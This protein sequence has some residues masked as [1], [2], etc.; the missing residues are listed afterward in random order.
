MRSLASVVRRA[1]GSGGIGV[2]GWV[3]RQKGLR[4]SGCDSSGYMAL[5][6]LGLVQGTSVCVAARRGSHRAHSL[7][8]G[9]HV[10]W[11]K[12]FA[13]GAWSPACGRV[14]GGSRLTSGRAATGRGV[15]AFGTMASGS[16]E[17]TIADQP[18]RFAA[19]KASGNK[20]VLDIES[21]YDPGLL[22]GQRVLVTGGNRGIGLAL[23]NELVA[24]GAH[25][26]ATCRSSSQELDSAGCAQIL[27]GCDV[28]D[29]ASCKAMAQAVE[30]TLDIVINNAGY[31][32][33]P[34]EKL[35]TLNFEE[36]IKMIDICA[37]GP[38]RVTSALVNAGKVKK[39]GG[40]V[41]VITSQ[42]GSVSW[43]TVQNPDGGD[44]G[45]H[46]SKAAANMGA[47]LL[48]QELKKDGI[49][50]SVLHPGF[51]KT[52]MTA[53]YA[54]IWEIEGAVDVSVGAKRVMHEINLQSMETTGKFINC[55]DGLQIPW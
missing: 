53:K 47:V 20:R 28:Q 14:G 54:H 22:K 38:L 13:A 30:G 26:V 4:V 27:M 6:G 52:D 18:A 11:A 1:R 45:H 41:S 50:V 49:S 43:R 40:K 2:G 33:G 5:P 32:Y 37:V 17:F 46:M 34:V 24:A 19:A 12:A 55:E 35:D 7:V 9:T 48:A 31:F 29:E 44:Y 42:G 3:G 21:V 8:A 25:V 23:V 16:G 15:R 51:N 36:E 10:A 39:P